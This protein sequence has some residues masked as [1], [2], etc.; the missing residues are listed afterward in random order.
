MHLALI[1]VHV[2]RLSCVCELEGLVVF[3]AVSGAWGDLVEIAS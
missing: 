2:P 3:I 1:V